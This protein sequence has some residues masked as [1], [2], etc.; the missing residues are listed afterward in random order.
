ML[1]NLIKIA[2]DLDGTGLTKEASF[3]D[4]VILKM[5]EETGGQGEAELT[6]QTEENSDEN[7]GELT[8]EELTLGV[9]EYDPYQAPQTVEPRP[10]PQSSMTPEQQAA[11]DKWLNISMNPPVAEEG[12]SREAL[13]Q[14]MVEHQKARRDA[15]LE[16]GRITNQLSQP[17][18]AAGEASPED[19]LTPSVSDTDGDGIPDERDTDDDGDG[20]PDSYEDLF[21]T[22]VSSDQATYGEP[23][24]I[25]TTEDGAKDLLKEA[26]DGSLTR[27][28]FKADIKGINITRSDESFSPSESLVIAVDGYRQI[29]AVMIP[30][31]IEAFTNQLTQGDFSY[32]KINVGESFSLNS[33]QSYLP[34]GQGEGA[35]E[36]TTEEPAQLLPESDI[37]EATTEEPAQL[38]PGSDITEAITEEG[39]ES[40]RP[41][42]MERMRGMTEEVGSK[43]KDFIGGIGDAVTGTMPL[44][45]RVS[46]AFNAFATKM[47]F[48]ND[49]PFEDKI[50]LLTQN[51]ISF[52]D[53]FSSRVGSISYPRDMSNNEM[54]AASR[55]WQSLFDLLL[56]NVRENRE[57][58]NGLEQ[59]ADSATSELTKEIEASEDKENLEKI[60]HDLYKAFTEDINGKFNRITRNYGE[61]NF[62]MSS[63]TDKDFPEYSSSSSWMSKLEGE[64]RDIVYN[65]VETRDPS[66][67][68]YST[69]FE[70]IPD[71]PPPDE[72]YS[73]VLGEV[74]DPVTEF[75]EEGD[76]PDET[77]FIEEDDPNFEQTDLEGKVIRVDIEGDFPIIENGI[78]FPSVGQMAAYLIRKEKSEGGVYTEF[79]DGAREYSENYSSPSPEE[80][81]WVIDA[82]GRV[83]DASPD[84][85]DDFLKRLNNMTNGGIDFVELIG[86]YA[87]QVGMEVELIG[88]EE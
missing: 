2:N 34:E 28:L 10:E 42:R 74:P 79:L 46:G 27:G 52:E 60:Y 64:N 75:K 71:L 30:E 32:Y 84:D 57:L 83:Y 73:D 66:D 68:D 88:D 61:P 18:P 49:L 76:D 72:D 59:V 63:D 87:E 54:R 8:E 15:Y 35:S 22:Y 39:S 20:I 26:P 11:Y 80:I 51:I 78:D 7:S 3:L 6:E 38:L 17:T 43:L 47:E 25:Y 33:L 77:S 13:K 81:Q 24:G 16:L 5:A 56:N 14:E 70:E 55:G 21:V 67:E 29:K 41:G 58:N 48:L 85:M 86:D 53:F 1:K 45:P 36:A 19:P 82:I 50:K 9:E 44:G 31:D 12:K 4:S 62:Q 23:I 40:E 69:V 65:S 37:P